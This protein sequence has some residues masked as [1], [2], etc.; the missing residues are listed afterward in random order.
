M[1]SALL[2]Y[3]WIP[4]LHMLQD[5]PISKIPF[6]N[7]RKIRTVHILSKN[8]FVTT[9]SRRENALSSEALNDT[10]CVLF[11]DG[12]LLL[13]DLDFGYSVKVDVDPL[14]CVNLTPNGEVC[15]LTEDNKLVGIEI[16]VG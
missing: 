12:T 9:N 10:A 7:G 8:Y 4:T 5:V 6:K 3:A 16:Q 11:D 13:I 2:V 14:K 15:G 1:S